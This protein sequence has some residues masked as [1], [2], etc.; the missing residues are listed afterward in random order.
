MREGTAPL[1]RREDYA[2]PP[3][4]IKKVDLTFDLDPAKTLV[5]NKMQI[6]R[7][8]DVAGRRRCACTARTSS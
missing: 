2:A 5:I 8:A 7:N 4:W 6:E 3:F 1:I